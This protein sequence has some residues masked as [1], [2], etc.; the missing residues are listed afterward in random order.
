LIAPFAFLGS[1][2]DDAL[3][4]VYTTIGPRERPQTAQP[5]G[6]AHRAMAWRTTLPLLELISRYINAE[7]LARVAREYQEKGRLLLIATTNLDARR[8]VIWNMGA[9][10]MA[11]R[12]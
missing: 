6:G 10:A 4:E 2:G 12:D 8:P 5:A 11:A 3:R 1:E 7:F 9:I